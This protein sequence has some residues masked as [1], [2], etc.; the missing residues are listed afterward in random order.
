MQEEWVEVAHLIKL[1][2]PRLDPEDGDG[3]GGAKDVSLWPLA[4]VPDPL[5]LD[6]VVQLDPGN[7]HA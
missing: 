5:V 3:E 6:D 4:K 7:H 1:F 2:L